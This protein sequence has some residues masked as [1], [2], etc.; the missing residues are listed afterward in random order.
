MK[1][2]NVKLYVYSNSPHI[3]A[4]LTG[5]LMLKK[6][7]KISLDI[8]KTAKPDTLPHEHIVFAEI[9]GMRIV[10][11]EADGY[12]C[13]KDVDLSNYIG[14]VDFYFKRSFSAKKNIDLISEGVRDRV[15]PLGFNYHVTYPN[16]PIDR[17]IG[18]R[19]K[20]RNYFSNQCTEHYFLP[21]VFEGKANHIIR[22]PQIIFMARLWN[23]EIETTFPVSELEYINSM[24]IRIIRELREKYGKNFIGGVKKDSYSLKTCPDI[25]MDDKYTDRKAYI[26]TMKKADICI[27]SI[28]LHE[29]IGW[30]TGEYV[31]AARAIVNERFRYEVP[32]GFEEGKNY[33]A[34]ASAK[35]C[36]KYVDLLYS[37]K[38]EIYNMK[39]ANEKYYREY[40]RPDKQV[41][42]AIRIAMGID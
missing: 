20:I 33:L 42:N 40:L 3:S 7:R 18:R 6:Q 10:F 26:K 36:L 24:R 41:G 32:G 2:L 29:S 8:E 4:I 17:E 19:H 25:V 38:D 35:E 34:F 11:D 15:Y 9:D 23:P 39:S 21:H 13:K 37:N 16:N 22:D 31:A 1:L 14:S 28:G 27:G 12:L 30:K 5:F